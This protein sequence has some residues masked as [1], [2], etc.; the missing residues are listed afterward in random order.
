MSYFFPFK[1]T[2]LPFVFF[3]EANKKFLKHNIYISAFVDS[4]IGNMTPAINQKELPTL[5]IQRKIP[6]DAQAKYYFIQ[7]K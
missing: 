1:H 4:S 7:I 6:I 3:E 2:G 5:E